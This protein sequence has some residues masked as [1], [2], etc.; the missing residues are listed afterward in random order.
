[1]T[2]KKEMIYF[3]DI[4]RIHLFCCWTKSQER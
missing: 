1:M 3:Y 2:T 4:L